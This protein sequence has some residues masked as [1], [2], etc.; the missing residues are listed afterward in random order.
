MEIC[1][2]KADIACCEIQKGTIK[3]NQAAKLV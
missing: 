3:E 2:M 1:E